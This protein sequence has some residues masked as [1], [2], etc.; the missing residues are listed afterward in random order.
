GAV[1]P[2]AAMSAISWAH[3]AAVIRIALGRAAPRTDRAR[4]GATGRGRRCSRRSSNC[5]CR[6]ALVHVRFSSGA[7]FD[8]LVRTDDDVAPAH[9]HDAHTEERDDQE[10]DPYVSHDRS[11]YTTAS[12]PGRAL[13][14]RRR[15][16]RD[17]D[18]AHTQGPRLRKTPRFLRGR[19]RLVNFGASRGP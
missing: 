4:R 17:L 19:Q 8:R 9:E 2:M 6:F 12:S 18:G 13:T 3:P 14:E 10:Q 1:T 5:A 11:S 15:L 16:R 7:R